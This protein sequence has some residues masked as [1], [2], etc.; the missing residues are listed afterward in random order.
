MKTAM[1][2]VLV[3]V[4]L[5]LSAGTSFAI[6][7]SATATAT[8]DIQTTLEVAVTWQNT[9]VPA[10]DF[11]TVSPPNLLTDYLDLE[12]THNMDPLQTFRVGAQVDKIA[13]PDWVDYVHLVELNDL[14]ELQWNQSMFG[15]VKEFSWAFGGVSQHFVEPIEVKFIVDATQ[16]FA[17]YE[18]SIEVFVT[19]L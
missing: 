19:S 4:L 15:T 14:E 8:F 13:G 18:F 2:V 11:G 5:C 7:A 16:P 10:Q 12:V 6:S 9:G 3:A 1:S 17:V